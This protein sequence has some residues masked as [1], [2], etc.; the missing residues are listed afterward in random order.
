MTVLRSFIDLYRRTVSFKYEL[1][2]L[3]QFA[4]HRISAW[5]VCHWRVVLL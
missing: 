3:V 1:S 2:W 4:R 5:I